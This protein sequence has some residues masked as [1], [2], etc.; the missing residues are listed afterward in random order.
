MTHD[1]AYKYE[2]IKAFAE[3]INAELTVMFGGKHWFHTKEQMQ[4]LDNWILKNQS[5]RSRYENSRF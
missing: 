4:F 1:Y 2:E 5:K 3:K